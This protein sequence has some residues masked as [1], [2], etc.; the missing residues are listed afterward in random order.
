MPAFLLLLL[1][2][3]RALIVGIVHRLKAP[4][5][6]VSTLKATRLRLEVT[7]DFLPISTIERVKGKVAK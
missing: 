1:E 7:L 5:P 3:Q 4:L 6:Q 2:E